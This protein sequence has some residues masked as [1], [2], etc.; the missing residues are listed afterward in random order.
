[1]KYNFLVSR[2]NILSRG[3]QAE[4]LRFRVALEFQKDLLEPERYDAGRVP[5]FREILEAKETDSIF[6]H[7]A[8]QPKHMIYTDLEKQELEDIKRKILVELDSDQY[9]LQCKAL[10][11]L[12][13][14]FYSSQWEVYKSQIAKQRE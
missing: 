5:S 8:L 10:S 7:P 12:S 2:L 13:Q 3:K 14:Q 6:E 4:A 9:V 1:M 11:D